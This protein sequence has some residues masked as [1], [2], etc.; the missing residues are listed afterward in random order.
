[1][2]ETAPGH[3]TI[4]SGR[5]PVHTGIIS[6][7]RGVPDATAPLIGSSVMGASPRRFMGIALFDWMIAS[8]STVRVLS[9]SRKDRARS[10]RSVGKDFTF[11]HVLPDAKSLRTKLERYPWMDS[12]T[13]A[14]ALDVVRAMRLGR[15]GPCGGG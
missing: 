5:E 7:N 11:P 9:V 2:T 1:M 4:L 15:R 12:V 8:D 14:F 10:F 6:N 3:S 13:L